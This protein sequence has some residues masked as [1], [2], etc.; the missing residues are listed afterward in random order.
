MYMTASFGKH[1]DKFLCEVKYM[2]DYPLFNEMPMGLGMA[3]MQN[4]MAMDYYSVLPD[5]E[6]QRIIN[7]TQTIGSKEEMQMYV[8]SIG[9]YGV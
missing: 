3:L 6:K 9:K 7:H 5:S 1:K 2:A 8:D 4:K